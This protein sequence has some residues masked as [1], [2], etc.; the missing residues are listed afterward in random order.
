MEHA[1]MK[2]VTHDAVTVDVHGEVLGKETQSVDQPLFSMAIVLSGCRIEPAQERP[3]HTTRYQ[4]IE[5]RHLGVDELFSRRGHANSVFDNRLS[6]VRK[7]LEF[8]LVFGVQR[9]AAFPRAV[10]GFDSVCGIYPPVLVWLRLFRLCIGR[11]VSGQD[12]P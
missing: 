3:L 11:A 8:M 6:Q 2:V 9:R 12:I 1:D 4:V 10:L 5:E 7:R